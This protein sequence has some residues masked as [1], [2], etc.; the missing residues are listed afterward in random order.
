MFRADLSQISFAILP[1]SPA[2]GEEQGPAQRYSK[3]F[4]VRTVSGSWE[5][6][7]P[8][9]PDH[10]L[11]VAAVDESAHLKWKQAFLAGLPECMQQDHATDDLEK[12]AEVLESQPDSLFEDVNGLDRQDP[13]N[14][15]AVHAS[16]AEHRDTKGQQTTKAFQPF[17]ETELAKAADP[18]AS[19]GDGDTGSPLPEMLK[20]VL[21]GSEKKPSAVQV[22][23][24]LEPG[25]AAVLAKRCP[26]LL[27]SIDRV[28]HEIYQQSMLSVKPLWHRLCGFATSDQWA[29]N[30]DHVLGQRPPDVRKLLTSL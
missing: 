20:L 21:R 11:I 9:T 2:S 7:G 1:S 19:D 15:A 4:H 22:K 29:R 16:G 12:Q 10:K 3:C 26:E 25:V 24:G 14:G 23:G 17:R 5:A 28:R 18:V 8:Q 13:K 27:T 6:G 30:G